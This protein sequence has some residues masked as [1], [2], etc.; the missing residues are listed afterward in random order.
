MLANV[1]NFST[2]IKLLVRLLSDPILCGLSEG[3]RAQLQ[4]LQCCGGKEECD[5]KYKYMIDYTY[6][7]MII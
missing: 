6:D 2:F 3:L 7:Y 5:V 4:S 1:N